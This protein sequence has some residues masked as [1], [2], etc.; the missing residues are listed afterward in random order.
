MAVGI[1]YDVVLAG[2]YAQRPAGKTLPTLS[3]GN[4]RMALLETAGELRLF[5]PARGCALHLLLLQAFARGAAAK[6]L[7]GRIMFWGEKL[8]C[9]PFAFRVGDQRKRWGSCSQRA[10]R[11]PKICLNWRALLLE[12]RLL[13]QLC[14][15]ELCH[16]REMNH[17]PAFHALMLAANPNSKEDERALGRAFAGL[18]PWAVHSSHFL[19]RRK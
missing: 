12:P 14:V 13:D 6:L 8:N 9:G 1:G 15:H 16:L 18:P 5:G 11:L 17:S 19:N 3:M 10:G 2:D 4:L 7:G